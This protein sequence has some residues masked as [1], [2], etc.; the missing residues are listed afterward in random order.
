MKVKIIEKSGGSFLY[1]TFVTVD[2]SKDYDGEA[3]VE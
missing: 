1:N 2:P 3:L